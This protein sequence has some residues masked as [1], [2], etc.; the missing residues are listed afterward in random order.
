MSITRHQL[1]DKAWADLRDSAEVPERLRRPVRRLQMLLA[2]DPAFKSVVDAA[3][4]GGAQAMQDIDESAAVD[5]MA[6]MGE[7]AFTRMDEMNDHLVI[8][9]VAGWSFAGEVSLEGLLDL[10]GGA[11]DALRTLCADGALGGGPD[12]SPSQDPE[13]PTAPSTGSVSR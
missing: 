6:G 12:F 7:T 4:S 10:P 13:S 8:S 11:Y 5:M 9:R 3:Q 2:A 1:P